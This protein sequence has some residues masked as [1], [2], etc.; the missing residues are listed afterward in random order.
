MSS[1]PIL[2]KVESIIIN[3]KN[4]TINNTDINNS[5]NNLVKSPIITKTIE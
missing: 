3:D 1:N 4:N 2:K 5:D